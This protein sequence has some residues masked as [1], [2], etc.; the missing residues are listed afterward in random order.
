LQKSFWGVERKFLVSV[1]GEIES[2]ESFVIQ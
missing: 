1:R 2:S